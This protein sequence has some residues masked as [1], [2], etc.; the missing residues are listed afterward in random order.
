MLVV[1]IYDNSDC[2]CLNKPVALGDNIGNINI[3]DCYTRHPG[4]PL[5]E[6]KCNK[7]EMLTLLENW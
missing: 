6:K 7:N 3:T 1:T 4:K 5:R 2:S